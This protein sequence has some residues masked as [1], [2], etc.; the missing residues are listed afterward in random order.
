MGKIHWQLENTFEHFGRAG[1]N[2]LGFVPGVDVRDGMLD[3]GFDDDARTRSENAV[4]DQLS[5]ILHARAATGAAPLTK[6]Q[7]FSANCN[8]TPVVSSIVDTSLVTLR[9]LKDVRILG[10][11]GSLRRSVACFGWDDRIELTRSPT[12]FSILGQQAA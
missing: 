11:D 8:D 4:V 5:R 9:D 2:S 12:L 6:K 10:P 3:F 1:F 7:L